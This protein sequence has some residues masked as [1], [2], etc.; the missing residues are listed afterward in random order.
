M[1]SRLVLPSSLLCLVLSSFLSRLV[2]SLSLF[3]F[4][5][6]LDPTFLYHVCPVFVLS[7]LALSFFGVIFWSS[8]GSFGIIFGRLGGRFGPLGLA[9]RRSWA[10]L[11]RLGAVL[12]R[13]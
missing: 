13:S 4:L 7:L 11:G 9:L 2:L 1:S 3:S 6:C 8:W 12:E 5:S 10:V